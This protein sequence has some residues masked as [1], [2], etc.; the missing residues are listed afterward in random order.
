MDLTSKN[1]NLVF[2]DCLFQDGEDTSNPAIA[3]GITSKFGFHKGRLDLRKEDISAMLSMLPKEFQK[4]GGGGMSFL[5]ACNNSNGK[6]WTDLHCVMDQ[7]F[8]LGQACEKVKCLM[9][10]DIWS[11]LPG[12]MPYYVVV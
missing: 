1:V 6:Q 2:M 11:A 9:P 5:N 10:R 12:G 3:E 8:S 4:N 7:L